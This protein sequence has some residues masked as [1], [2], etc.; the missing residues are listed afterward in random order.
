MDSDP[1]QHVQPLAVPVS[2]AN[3]LVQIHPQFGVQAFTSLPLPFTRRSAGRTLYASQ[4]SLRYFSALGSRRINLRNVAESRPPISKSVRR[5]AV[6]FLHRRRRY[7][8]GPA[9]IAAPDFHSTFGA[10]AR[11]S[12]VVSACA[13]VS[14][15]QDFSAWRFQPIIQHQRMLGM[16]YAQPPSQQSNQ[17]GW[18]FAPSLFSLKKPAQSPSP[19]PRPCALWTRRTFPATLRIPTRYARRAWARERGFRCRTRTFSKPRPA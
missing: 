8:R 7:P 16:P 18:E 19:L 10:T 4:W 17:A 2:L 1:R 9:L 13:S 5:A 14:H 3:Q 12:H 6:S 11:A 15:F